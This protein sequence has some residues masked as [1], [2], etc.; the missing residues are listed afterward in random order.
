MGQEVLICHV[1]SFIQVLENYFRQEQKI[2]AIRSK[3]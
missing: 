3:A 1:E 2:S